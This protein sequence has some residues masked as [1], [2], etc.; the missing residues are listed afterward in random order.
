[1]KRQPNS[2]FDNNYFNVDLKDWQV[3]MNIQSVFNEYKTVTFMCQHFSKLNIIVHKPQNWQPEAFEN[4][5]HH[6]ETM[7]T[8]AKAYL[9]NQE[10]SV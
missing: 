6:H 8:I 10:Y 5:I 9:S 3:N 7:K 2:S 1:M 4:N